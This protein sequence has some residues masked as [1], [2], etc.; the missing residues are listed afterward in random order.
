MIIYITVGNS[1]DKLTQRQWAAL[2]SQVDRIVD[3]YSSA[4]HGRWSSDPQSQWQN[5]CWCV[6]IYTMRVAA[7]AKTALEE[8]A[9][10]YGQDAIAWAE[11]TSLEFFNGG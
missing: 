11:V 3:R 4:V 5:A 6:E 8:T 2:C 1:G 9:A 10:D 7:E